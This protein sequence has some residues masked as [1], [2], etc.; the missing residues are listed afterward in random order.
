MDPAHS[1]FHAGGEATH[2]GEVLES[3]RQSGYATRGRVD[4]L[5]AVADIHIVVLYSADGGLNGRQLLVALVEPLHDPNEAVDGIDA[6]TILGLEPSKDGRLCEF[7]GC[8]LGLPVPQV[9]PLALHDLVKLPQ[10]E[11]PA[12]V[13]AAGLLVGLDELRILLLLQ[14][15][16]GSTADLIAQDRAVLVLI[17][18]FWGVRVILV[19]VVVYSRDE[20]NTLNGSV[21][22][23]LDILVGFRDINFM[24]PVGGEG[25][26]HGRGLVELEVAVHLCDVS[27]LDRALSSAH[28]AQHLFRQ[29][30]R[31]LGI[32]VA[33]ALD[34]R[35]ALQ[36]NVVEAVREGPAV[37]ILHEG[38]R[39]SP[40]LRISLP[41]LVT[42]LPARAKAGILA[43]WGAREADK[44]GFLVVQ[45]DEGR[46]E[47]AHTIARVLLFQLADN[48]DA[49]LARSLMDLHL[50]VQHGLLPRLGRQALN[51]LKSLC[52]ELVIR[53]LVLLGKTL[54]EG[55]DLVIMLALVHVLIEQFPALDEILILLALLEQFVRFDRIQLPI[56]LAGFTGALLFTG[57]LLRQLSR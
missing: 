31:T 13:H 42:I 2:V 9:L 46:V 37:R 33:L 1:A 16:P 30:L 21:P 27:V 10:I 26:D 28:A 34:A 4:G 44:R 3:P 51:F 29:G 8:H 50:H 35:T 7:F 22:R 55:L 57:I 5:D 15:A 19:D 32:L 52:T 23:A 25:G 41:D 53:C 14:E 54:E 6:G 56:S 45:M 12:A 11:L 36:E 48:E 24:V 20:T 47:V 17:V 18:V 39:G 49:I 43:K 38:H 40:V